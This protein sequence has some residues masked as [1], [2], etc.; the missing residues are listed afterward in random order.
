MNVLHGALTFPKEDLQHC[1]FFRW[2]EGDDEQIS[3]AALQAAAQ[4]RDGP[5]GG[6]QGAGE[7]VDDDEDGEGESS[8]LS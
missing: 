1:I 2:Q 8:P 6:D 5:E 4:V 3:L 7:R